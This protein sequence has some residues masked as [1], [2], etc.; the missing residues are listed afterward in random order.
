MPEKAAAPTA[1]PGPSATMPDASA[2]VTGAPSTDSAAYP[3]PAIQPRDTTSPA[4]AVPST[5]PSQY[6]TPTAQSWLPVL[7]LIF[8]VLVVLAQVWRGRRGDAVL[9][10]VVVAALVAV[11][12]GVDDWQ[13]AAL[14][15]LLGCVGGFAA[16]RVGDA[17][18]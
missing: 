15:G 5:E 10:V 16:A 9:S 3:G 12:A 8:G 1:Y 14:M 13:L 6:G 4:M 17:A 2:P 7:V 11:L 18:H